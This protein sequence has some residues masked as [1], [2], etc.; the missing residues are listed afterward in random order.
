MLLLQFLRQYRAFVE[1]RRQLHSA[2]QRIRDRR[3]ASHTLLPVA[4]HHAQLLGDDLGE[5]GMPRPGFLL[6]KLKDLRVQID[7]QCCAHV[8]QAT[9]S[10]PPLL[11][12]LVA[13]AAESPA[14]PLRGGGGAQNGLERGDDGSSPFRRANNSGLKGGRDGCRRGGGGWY[15]FKKSFRFRRDHRGLTPFRRSL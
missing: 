7:R 5:R 6:G 12:C 15:S 3:L 10:S 9:A 13:F 2:T 4:G 8:G 1:I 11:R 14:V